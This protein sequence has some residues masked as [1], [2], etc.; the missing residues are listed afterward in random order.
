MRTFLIAFFLVLTLP[1]QAQLAKLEE[2]PEI[3]NVTD[4][5]FEKL[6]V[7]YINQLRASPKTFIPLLLEYTHLHED[8]LKRNEFVDSICN[9]ID[10]ELIP[11][12]SKVKPLKPLQYNSKLR[13]A[14]NNHFTVDFVE[15]KVLD[16]DFQHLLPSF[17]VTTCLESLNSSTSNALVVV[18]I[19]DQLIGYA[20]SSHSDRNNILNPNFNI[21]AIRLVYFQNRFQS[22]AECFIIQDYCKNQ[23]N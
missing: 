10:Y 18:Y 23:E 1:V 11:L 16:T 5:Q 12:L 22:N 19:I 2:S 7:Q 20:D 3:K 4:D 15:K 14:M 17:N 21:I 13:E 8:V 9:I 6:S